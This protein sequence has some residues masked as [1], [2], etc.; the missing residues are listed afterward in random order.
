MQSWELLNTSLSVNHQLIILKVF[1][2]TKAKYE[3]KERKIN[4]HFVMLLFK[5]DT[6][7]LNQF[8]SSN[9]TMQ[10]LYN[11]MFLGSIGMDCAISKP[12]YKGTILPRINRNFTIKWS[13]SYIIAL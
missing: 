8:I 2:F 1:Y 9:K 4:C 10:S 6:Y 3:Q 11:A 12:C 13:F 7:Q 5:P